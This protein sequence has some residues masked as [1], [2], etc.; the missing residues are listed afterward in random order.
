MK[1]KIN[2]TI[3]NN[4]DWRFDPINGTGTLDIMTNASLAELLDEFGEGNEIIEYDDNDVEKMKWYNACVVSIAETNIE[5]RTVTTVF[6]MSVINDGTEQVLQ[7]NI[8]E[9]ID[10]IIEIADL[11]ADA[12]DSVNSM[13]TTVDST[14]ALA[15]NMHDSLN[16]LWSFYNRLADR[17]AALENKGA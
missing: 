8:D 13:Q 11:V 12:L 1:I 5:N 10:G 6:R 9:C 16:R 4:V 17:V 7:G 3:F 14:S 2:D 15:T